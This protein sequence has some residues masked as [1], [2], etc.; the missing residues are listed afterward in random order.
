MK[1]TDFMMKLYFNVRPLLH[2]MSQ[3]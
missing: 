2:V 1:L 3:L